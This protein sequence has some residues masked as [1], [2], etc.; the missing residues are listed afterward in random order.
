MATDTRNEAGGGV[1]S[2]MSGIV[3]DVE[4]LITQQV[5]LTGG[6]QSGCGPVEG[7]RRRSSFR[8]SA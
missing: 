7:W 4:N 8:A 6:D 5:Q 3:S 2:L 1:P